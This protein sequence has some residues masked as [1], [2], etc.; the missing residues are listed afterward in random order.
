MEERANSDGLQPE[1]FAEQTNRVSALCWSW[2]GAG[3]KAFC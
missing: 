2:A 3:Q 1:G